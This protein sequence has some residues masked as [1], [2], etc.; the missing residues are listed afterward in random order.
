MVAPAVCAKW[1][2]PELFYLVYKGT[3]STNASMAS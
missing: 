1:H 2:T 3:Y